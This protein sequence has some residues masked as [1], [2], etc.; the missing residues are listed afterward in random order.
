[1]SPIRVLVVDD[2]PMMREALCAA[3]EAEPDLEVVGEATNGH[4][5]VL[6]TLAL[7]PDVIVMDLYL[8]GKD[9]VAAIAEIIARYPEARILVVTSSTEDEK[10][11]AAVQAGAIGYLL[12]NAP[13]ATFIH[14]VREV[15]R[16]NSFM[17]PEVAAKL[18]R[19][20]CRRETGPAV[21]DDPVEPLTPREKEVLSLLG[22]GMSNHAIALT[23]SLSES[24][25]RVHV[26]NILGKLGL[27]DR[28]QA[29]VYALRQSRPDK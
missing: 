1:M 9:G 20:M 25:V 26:Y 18:A 24:T 10:V 16:G 29:I 22:E 6:R 11:M 28:N 15:A 14:G 5:A 4:Q 23:L 27:E 13:R 21:P 12:K 2:H 19:Q 7:K 8:P 3:L 17:P